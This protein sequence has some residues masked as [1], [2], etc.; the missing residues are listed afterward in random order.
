MLGNV[1]R[2]NRQRWWRSCS[3][4]STPQTSIFFRDDLGRRI[5]ER[6]IKHKTHPG[7]AGGMKF[8][9]AGDHPQADPGHMLEVS[10]LCSGARRSHAIEDYSLTI[11]VFLFFVTYVYCSLFSFLHIV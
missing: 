5:D 8:N 4:G 3:G 7:F 10:D 6:W 2:H 11:F 9:T 1:P